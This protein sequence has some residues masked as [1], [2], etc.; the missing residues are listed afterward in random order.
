VLCGLDTAEA[1]GHRGSHRLQDTVKLGVSLKRL[2]WEEGFRLTV[3][4]VRTM[5]TNDTD[6]HYSFEASQPGT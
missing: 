1:T 4:R 2:R 6:S 3:G 5:T